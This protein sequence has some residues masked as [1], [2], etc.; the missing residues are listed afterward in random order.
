MMQFKCVGGPYHNKHITL[1]Q[2][3]REH[4]VQ[5]CDPLPEPF[6]YPPL[7]MTEAV[8][9][10]VHRAVYLRRSIKCNGTEVFFYAP[11]DWSDVEAIRKLVE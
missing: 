7:P 4:V 11:Q 2:A 8:E 5:W 6:V 10:T 9:T 1:E 3:D